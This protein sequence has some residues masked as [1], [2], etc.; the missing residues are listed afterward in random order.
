MRPSAWSPFWKHYLVGHR[1]MVS[2]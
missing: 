1:S 2:F